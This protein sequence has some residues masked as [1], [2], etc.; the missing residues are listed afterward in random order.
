MDR[1]LQMFVGLK[2]M[3]S[4]T[5]DDPDEK[6]TKVLIDKIELKES[7][8]LILIRI[9]GSHFVWK[10]VR[11]IV[12]VCVEVGRNKLSIENVQRYLKQKSAEPARL[13]A[14]PSGLFLERIYYKGDAQNS[15]LKPTINL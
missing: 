13:T 2:D 10:L 6:S 4:F 5:D 15:V 1:A 8:D 7:G 14:P 11:R 9:I 3:Q 12:G